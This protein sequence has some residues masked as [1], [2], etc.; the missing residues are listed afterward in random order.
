MPSSLAA[1]ANTGDKAPQLPP[2]SPSSTH[3]SQWEERATKFRSNLT[4]LS[5]STS[6]VGAG[7]RELRS[8]WSPATTIHSAASSPTVACDSPPPPVPSLP[9]TNINS[10]HLDTQ[11]VQPEM[12]A[13]S[14]STSTQGKKRP[15]PIELTHMHNKS[16]GTLVEQGLASAGASQPAT[17]LERSTTLSSQLRHSK[18]MRD[19]ERY[20]SNDDRQQ[21]SM[22][23]RFSFWKRDRGIEEAESPNP[24]TPVSS[25]SSFVPNRLTT[26]RPLNILRPTRPP[27]LLPTHTIHHHYHNGAAANSSAQQEAKPV[28]VHNHIVIDGE[29]RDYSEDR[30]SKKNRSCFFF[31]GKKQKPAKKE[32]K[33][34]F[35]LILLIII[36]IYLLGNN[37]FLNVKVA[38]LTQP[39]ST[40]DGGSSGTGGSTSGTGGVS[41]AV[42]D[43]ISQF[44]L[45]AASNP[46]S[47]PCSTCASILQTVPNDF[48]SSNAPITG[49]GAALQFCALGDIARAASNSSA[50]T[51]V[52]WLKDA[53]PCGSWSGVQCDTQGRV[54]SLTLVFPGVPA[55]L[56]TSLPAGL[57]AVKTLSI[58]GDGNVPTG[59]IFVS[60]STNSTSNVTSVFAMPSL[61]T[62]TVQ[63]TALTGPLS[64]DFFKQST[65]LTSLTLVKNPQLGSSLPS[66]LFTSPAQLKSVIVNGQ[67][68]SSAGGAITAASNAVK[69]SLTTLDLST[70]SLSGSIPDFSAFSALTEVNLS[71]NQFTSLS[72]SS[73]S[74]GF[75]SGLA[76]LNVAGNSGLGGS[77]PSALCTAAGSTLQS[78]DL[79]STELG[80][81]GANAT[82]GSCGSCLFGSL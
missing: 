28:Q 41:Q 26:W 29:Q 25:A 53:D 70:N 10:N 35:W 60:S 42:K 6:V 32:K 30:K 44:K 16:H 2:I 9:P 8:R 39:S 58:T 76:T 20:G 12:P 57:V 14:T 52:G 15:D 61:Q 56:P 68:L 54:S 5:T 55:T 79:R 71:Q 62:L 48:S 64:D 49:Q 38:Q 3:L 59:S 74:D 63:S 81:N 13:A 45:N 17:Q 34:R 33:G 78:C 40:S 46:T 72:S 77:V 51:N 27:I 73:S 69:S 50:L 36:L 23:A 75:P 67:S 43:C 65:N 80:L 18:S 82:T 31:C 21:R 7:N 66:S 47:Y 11:E 24:A 1:A 19:A 37:V 22:F 4:H